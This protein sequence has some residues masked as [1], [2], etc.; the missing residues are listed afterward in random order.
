[1]DPSYIE[2]NMHIR[3]ILD[4]DICQ[5]ISLCEKINKPQ[6][7]G[8]NKDGLGYEYN[9]YIWIQNTLDLYQ[10][11][12][13]AESTNLLI[14]CFDGDKLIG[15]LTASVI[16]GWYDGKSVANMHDVVTDFERDDYH[17]IF[18]M[19]FQRFLDYYKQ[20]YITNWRAD[21]I[22]SNNE[23][24]IKFGEFIKKKFGETNDIALNVSVRGLMK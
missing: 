24:G 8:P 20:F 19:L 16:N 11:T 1:M 17:L 21:T 3:K 10:A 9:E 2:D 6:A 12:R 23:S 5:L 18:E 15:F 7:T 4:N 13:T 22:R 14:G